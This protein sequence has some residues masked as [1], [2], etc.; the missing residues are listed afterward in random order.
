MNFQVLCESLERG[1]LP[2][3]WTYNNTDWI[4]SRRDA[5]VDIVYTVRARR[6]GLV[7]HRDVRVDM[8]EIVPYNQLAVV[9]AESISILEFDMV[10]YAR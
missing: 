7:L 8:F 3:S 10:R 5:P 6:G 2:L 9:I 4:L 1:F